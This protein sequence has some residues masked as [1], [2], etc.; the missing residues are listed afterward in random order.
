MI[1]LPASHPQKRPAGLSAHRPPPAGSPVRIQSHIKPPP[2]SEAACRTRQISPS[3][4][5]LLT[6]STARRC[7]KISQSPIR[8]SP[9]I[10]CFHIHPILLS[11]IVL[12]RLPLP[13]QISSLHSQDNNQQNHIHHH[14]YRSGDHRQIYKHSRPCEPVLI[15][16]PLRFIQKNIISF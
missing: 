16:Y 6:R 2:L 8:L 4:C 10:P 12:L 14:F 1:S 5:Y 3:F 9:R 13:G 11:L 7:K 15:L